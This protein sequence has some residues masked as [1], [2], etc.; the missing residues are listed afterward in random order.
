MRDRRYLLAQHNTRRPE[1]L[2]KWG[3]PGGKMK[4]PEAP[5]A[6][7]RRELVE[8]LRLE[9]P[10]LV[11]L[12]D[13]LLRGQTHRVFGCEIDRAV[14]WFDTEEILGIAWFS[15]DEVAALEEAGQLQKGFELGAI[16]AF[17]DRIEL[18]YSPPRETTARNPAGRRSA[19]AA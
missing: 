2:G 5:K 10:Y 14:G 13:W 8:E 4:K 17:R 6:A 3:L 18:G 7:L 16:R 1:K 12:G 15:F 9:V 19:S 11:E